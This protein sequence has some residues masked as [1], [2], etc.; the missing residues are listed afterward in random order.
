[1][2]FLK[3]REICFGSGS[4]VARTYNARGINSPSQTWLNGPWPRSW[5]RPASVTQRMS[6]SSIPNVGWWRCKCSTICLA[7]SATP[8][9]TSL[10]D[11]YWELNYLFTNAVF[12]S[13]VRGPR[14]DVIGSTQ[15]LQ[16]PE[17]LELRSVEESIRA[18]KTRFFPIPTCLWMVKYTE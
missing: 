5:S 15:L 13:V 6:R 7:R 18:R 16:V 11:S 2:F 17:S 9:V 1:V 10:R 8:Y 3:F 4:H 12:K 14:K